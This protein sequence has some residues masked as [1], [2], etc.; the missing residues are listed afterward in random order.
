METTGYTILTRQ[1]GLMREMQV[2][3]N[4]IANLSTA[5]FRR[6]GVIFSE[7]VARAGADPSLSM[8]SASGR[9]VDLTQGALTQT[10][11]TW[12]FAITGPGF[13]QI[14]TPEGPRLTRAGAFG[15]DPAGTVVNRDGHALLDEGGAPVAVPPGA[16][17]VSLGADGTLSAD[18][19][20]FARVG[21]WEAQ[22]DNALQHEG[23]TRFLATGDLIPAE[24]AQ[25]L[26]GH[27][28]DSNVDPV[29]EMARMIEVQRSY[30][31]GQTFLDRED[32]RLRGLIQTVF[33]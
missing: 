32:G 5:G 20:P 3:A 27:L 12:D 22:G 13:F 8:A 29:T 30:E 23:G 2:V 17:L 33:R 14:A 21:I 16:T 28:E 7:H 24:G 19:V 9:L 4:N 26:Q 31:L 18:G 10:R 1:S 25:V 6:E 11:G 15:P